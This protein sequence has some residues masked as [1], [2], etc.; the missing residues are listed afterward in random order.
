MAEAAENI[1]CRSTSLYSPFLLHAA[2]DTEFKLHS[3]SF[4]ISTAKT[5]IR[6]KQV[7]TL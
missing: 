6:L 1:H 2:N 7:I 3:N 4:K 5:R